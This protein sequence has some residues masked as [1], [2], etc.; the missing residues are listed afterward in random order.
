[1]FDIARSR[2][3]PAVI[4]SDRGAL[5]GK[6][7]LPPDCWCA[8]ALFIVLPP[9]S[10]HSPPLLAVHLSS[11]C[12]GSL[13]SL[14]VHRFSVHIFYPSV[15]ILFPPYSCHSPLLLTVHLSSICPGSLFSPLCSSLFCPYIF[16]LSV[17]ILFPPYSWRSPLLL[18]SIYLLSVRVHCSPSLFLA[19]S[20]TSRCPSIFYRSIYCLSTR[21]PVDRLK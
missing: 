20:F 14:F 1:M 19:L 8:V 2:A 11:I 16:Y 13:F 18:T 3:N 4:L 10:S 12:P 6:A 9:Y 21:L 15:S 5:D 17:S 7:Y